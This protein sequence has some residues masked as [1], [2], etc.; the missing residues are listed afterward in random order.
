LERV[1]KLKLSNSLEY[2]YGFK[3]GI[4]IKFYEKSLYRFIKHFRELKPMLE[5]VKNDQPI[6]YG[7]LPFKSFEALTEQGL[8]IGLERNEHWLRWPIGRVGKE[9][10]LSQRCDRDR[11]GHQDDL[12][13]L[14]YQQ[15]RKEVIERN[16]R[17]RELSWQNLSIKL[18]SGREQLVSAGQFDLAGIVTSERN[19]LLELMEFD[20]A[21]S[22]PIQTMNKVME[23][24]NFLR[25]R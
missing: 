14:N 7:G 4:F 18:G 9:G 20:L 1:E 8:V 15:W 22:T 16:K 3:Q 11:P 23:W 24:Q 10:E 19:I 25:N 21:I 2:I 17:E 6:V 12:E 13:A 5:K